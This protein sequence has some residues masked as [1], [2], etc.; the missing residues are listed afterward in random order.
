MSLSLFK[1]N[2]GVKVSDYVTA[3]YATTRNPFLMK[4][5]VSNILEKINCLNCM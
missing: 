5:I 4:N 1:L 3:K 2:F